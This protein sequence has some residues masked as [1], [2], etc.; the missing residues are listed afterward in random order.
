MAYVG[1]EKPVYTNFHLVPY[2]EEWVNYWAN[3]IYNQVGVFANGG[4]KKYTHDVKCGHR[5]NMEYLGNDLVINVKRLLEVWIPQ[6]K[7]TYKC[8][9]VTPFVHTVLEVRWS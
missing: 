8:I 9:S 4:S 7:I 3:T 2:R 1:V 5:T 6:C